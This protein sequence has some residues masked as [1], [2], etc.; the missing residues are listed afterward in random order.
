MVDTPAVGLF[1][2]HDSR[3]VDRSELRFEVR[4][5]RVSS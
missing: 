1:W 4:V 3:E 2:L 5:V